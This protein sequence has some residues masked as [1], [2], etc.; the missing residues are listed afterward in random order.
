MVD[1]LAPQAARHDLQLYEYLVLVDAIRGGRAREKERA[2]TELRNRLD[3]Y[4]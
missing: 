2:T 1:T 3:H 4:A